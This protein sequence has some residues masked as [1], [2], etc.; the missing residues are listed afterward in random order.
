M[1]TQALLDIRIMEI[2]HTQPTLFG[3][4]IFS[5][6]YTLVND[7]NE[8]PLLDEQ[9]KPYNLPSLPVAERTMCDIL[10]PGLRRMADEYAE[11]EAMP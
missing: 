5:S 10:R 11:S 6:T 9:G 1:S 3:S 2:V 8:Q 4:P 7:E